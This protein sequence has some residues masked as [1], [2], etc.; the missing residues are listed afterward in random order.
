MFSTVP[1]SPF[2]PVLL[3]RLNVTINRPT[4]SKKRKNSVCRIHTFLLHFA[5]VKNIS[6]WNSILNI[7]D[8]IMH[9][10]SVLSLFLSNQSN[11]SGSTYTKSRNFTGG[12]WLILVST[13]LVA[14]PRLKSQQASKKNIRSEEFHFGGSF[15]H[16]CMWGYP[17]HNTWADYIWEIFLYVSYRVCPQLSSN[18][19]SVAKNPY[20]NRIGRFNKITRY[21]YLKVSFAQIANYLSKITIICF[22]VKTRMILCVIRGGKCGHTHTWMKI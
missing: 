19:Q 2:Y 12:S 1:Q 11:T 21:Y 13:T 17:H 4:W 7:F 15:G 14:K 9:K 18:F 22:S 3:T 16:F 20:V 10:L 8:I 6:F 5:T